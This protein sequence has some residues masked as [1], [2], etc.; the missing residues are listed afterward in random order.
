M[1]ETT[2]SVDNLITLVAG[3]LVFTYIKHQTQQ[4]KSGWT[5]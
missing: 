5:Y 3:H 1:V 4:Y 2:L